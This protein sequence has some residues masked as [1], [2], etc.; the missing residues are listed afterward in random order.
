MRFE[1]REDEKR[2]NERTFPI[3]FEVKVVSA[4]MVV[5]SATI[6]LEIV[7][8]DVLDDEY[9]FK[10]VHGRSIRVEKRANI[11]EVIYFEFM[12]IPPL[13]D[14]GPVEEHVW[15]S[16][17][18]AL[19]LDWVPF[20]IGSE[21]VLLLNDLWPEF[22]VELDLCRGYLAADPV[23]SVACIDASILAADIFY[24]QNG[25]LVV[26][27][28]LEIFLLNFRAKPINIFLAILSQPFNTGCWIR[29]YTTV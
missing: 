14:G 26:R 15:K 20:D 5:G 4:Q 21:F 28:L 18:L 17:G 22:N 6:L 1:R 25:N 24:G 8:F 19:D 13:V 9:G 3:H 2:I 23:R 29:V 12:L 27:K 10:H 11:A 16:M 7:L